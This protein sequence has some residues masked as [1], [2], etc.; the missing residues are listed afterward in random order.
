MELNLKIAQSPAVILT[1][2]VDK[3]SDELLTSPVVVVVVVDDD[4]V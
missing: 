2:L 3:R 1:A 4:V